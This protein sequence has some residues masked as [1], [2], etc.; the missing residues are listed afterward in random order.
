[1]NI[2]RQLIQSKIVP[3]VS[4]YCLALGWQFEVVDLRWGISTEAAAHHRTM[5]ICLSELQHCQEVSPK[6]NFLLLLGQRYGW[7]PLPEKIFAEDVI[8]LLENATE[9]ERN[10]FNQ[11]YQRNDNTIPCLYELVPDTNSEEQSLNQKV[12]FSEA[13]EILRTLFDNCAQISGNEMWRERYCSSATEQ[14]IYYGLLQQKELCN[15]TIYY[16]RILTQCPEEV[17]SVY[18]ESSRKKELSL[19]RERVNSI[20]PS[21]NTISELISYDDYKSESYGCRFVDNLT[22]HIKTIVKSEID[23]CKYL[24]DQY[25]EELEQRA[26]VDD[27]DNSFIG[28]QYELEE[29][30][31]YLQTNNPNEICVVEAASG[32]GKTMLLARF[33]FLHK[34]ERIISRFIGSSWLSSNGIQVLQ[35]LLSAL[36]ISYKK[37]EDYFSLS[38]KCAKYLRETSMPILVVIDGLDYLRFDDPMLDMSWLPN[39]LPKNVKVIL[40]KSSEFSITLLNAS[41]CLKIIKL[42][43]IEAQLMC[44]CLHDQL[45]KLG[46]SLSEQQYL[47][48][49]DC[50]TRI[51]EHPLLLPIVRQQSLRWRSEDEIQLPCKSTEEC[52]DEYFDYLCR[53]E[54]NDKRF[55]ALVLGLLC[56]TRCG[57]TEK[58]LLD[59]TA[60]DDLYYGSLLSSSYHRLEDSSSCRKTPYVIWTK[61][62]SELK[63]FLV[64]RK[65]N[66]GITFVFSS[67]EITKYARRYVE[68][69]FQVKD[70]VFNLIQCYFERDEGF[71][72]PRTLEELSYAYSCNGKVLELV[73]LLCNPNY[74]QAKCAHGMIED[75]YNEVNDALNNNSLDPGHILELECVRNFLSEQ[76]AQLIKY[77]KYGNEVSKRLARYKKEQQIQSDIPIRRILTIP[78]SNTEV[79]TAEGNYALICCYLDGDSNYSYSTCMLWDLKNNSSFR[80]IDIPLHVDFGRDSYTIRRLVN[81]V[82]SDNGGK[83]A[84]YDEF[85]TLWLW[86]TDSNYLQSV[87]V[88]IQDMAFGC[89]DN[90]YCLQNGVLFEF[91]FNSRDKK[92]VYVGGEGL[93]KMCKDNIHHKF[94]IFDSNGDVVCFDEDSNG[95]TMYHM[96][97]KQVMRITYFDAISRQVWFCYK[98]KP[99][100]LFMYNLDDGAMKQINLPFMAFKTYAGPLWNEILCYAENENEFR[101]YNIDDGSERFRLHTAQTCSVLKIGSCGRPQ[102][103]YTVTCNDFTLWE[104]L[105]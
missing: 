83:V 25:E 28:R 46:R 69:N 81:S 103:F 79:S 2:E 19:L 57:I 94:Y 8:L 20:V 35:S 22:R 40:S 61:L 62:Y 1:M 55:V 102:Y 64:Q 86:N 74:V 51:G 24:D 37:S 29:L 3:E 41:Y 60:S 34:S 39:P 98:E 12:N 88:E 58:E 66:S 75:L 84:L 105:K 93:Y 33:L 78:I 26:I 36:N 91:D 77:G 59:I 15:N 27:A 32:L 72:N 70:L 54:N 23:A 14:E 73:T 87:N 5:N 38:R 21:E 85:Q 99:D 17:S 68:N 89:G 48:F 67:R 16:N 44:Q 6:P 104:W 13:E 76:K 90:L 53:P 97:V 7:I 30:E 42:K 56:Y 31:K 47:Q 82:I 11:W 4:R 9:Y 45:L 10:I 95:V 96:P 50:Y 52:L 43:T 49:R 100:F 92:I 101:I 71:G 65:T 63:C 80:H 18:I